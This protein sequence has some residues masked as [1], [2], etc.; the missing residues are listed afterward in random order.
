MRCTI[1]AFSVVVMI[2]LMACSSS[3]SEKLPCGFG[4]ERVDGRCTGILECGE[5]TFLQDNQCVPSEGSS[6]GSGTRA[7][8]GDCIPDTD[9][10]CAEGTT[11][12][13][14]IC[15]NQNVIVCG[16]GTEDVEGDCL[17][18]EVLECGAGTDRV[19]G[20]DGSSTCVPKCD[21]PE[22]WDTVDAAC[23]EQCG[24]GTIYVEANGVCERECQDDEWYDPT[25]DACY[26]VPTCGAGTESVGDDCEAWPWNE[27]SLDTICGRRARYV[28]DTLADCCDP[29]GW[30]YPGD[31]LQALS[32][33]D[34]IERIERA[35]EDIIPGDGLLVGDEMDHPTCLAVELTRCEL[36]EIAAF[37]DMASRGVVT[38][39]DDA[40]QAFD[41][42]FA[43]PVDA[44]T[45]PA[46]WAQWDRDL[47]TALI[48]GTTAKG[49]TCT[50]TE[51][52]VDDAVCL[53]VGE[54]EQGEPI[55]QCS[56][57]IDEDEPC[58]VF[59]HGNLFG[60]YLYD[61]NCAAGFDCIYGHG[62]LSGNYCRARP[63][64]DDP[65]SDYFYEDN[66][67]S[68][69]SS[70][71]VCE[72][73]LVCR[74][75]HP[76]MPEAELAC[77]P[78]LGLADQCRP[79]TS[80]GQLDLCGE[81]FWCDDDALVDEERELE[82][83]PIG[84]CSRGQDDGSDCDYCTERLPTYSFVEAP[85][86]SCSVDSTCTLEE[87]AGDGDE[88]TYEGVCAGAESV[89]LNRYRNPANNMCIPI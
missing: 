9:T 3:D 7:V 40:V 45:R 73:G 38:V 69:A 15:V 72:E 89:C 54:T 1:T 52:C 75:D 84:Q 76:I 34:R 20:D 78:W 44:C 43:E 11:P 71:P 50:H 66:G 31:P 82:Y 32:Q 16:A 77:R 28:C 63:G 68:Y 47:V 85:P 81:G 35:A 56:D 74:R 36:S 12:V 46:G 83:G 49:N 80:P 57:P 8:D 67:R 61:D 21:A 5:G 41:D 87:V 70:L 29:L 86:S 14:G 51:Q 59:T 79:V 6:C 23:V 53:R 18:T 4:T 60:R 58:D 48:T 88:M 13:D 17:P 65:C 25:D 33:L 64:A 27:V 39:N 22:I 42:Y 30:Y 37:R 26:A 2:G 55:Y 19:D 62:E 10:V 24:A